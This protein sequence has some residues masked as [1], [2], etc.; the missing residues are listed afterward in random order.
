MLMVQ[1]PSRPFS[2]EARDEVLIQRTGSRWTVGPKVPTKSEVWEKMI[3]TH[4]LSRV[5]D[6]IGPVGVYLA[7]TAG[8]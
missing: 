3:P 7:K 5:Q 8:R 1:P 6:F 2:E 4:P